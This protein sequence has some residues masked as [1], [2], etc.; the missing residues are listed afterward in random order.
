MSD[1]PRPLTPTMLGVL[2]VLARHPRDFWWTYLHVVDE[3][4]G[5]RASLG[6]MRRRG[7]VDRMVDCGV[8]YW[9]IT[10]AGRRAVGGGDS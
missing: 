3:A 10:D 1:T 6:A 5:A 7:L 8:T 2:H 4:P 9:Q